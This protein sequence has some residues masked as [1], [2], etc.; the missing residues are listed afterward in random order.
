LQLGFDVGESLLR[1]L[2]LLLQVDDLQAVP[3]RDGKT[4]MAYGNGV[5]FAIKF[6]RFV[7]VN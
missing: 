4:H 3:V 1:L 6:A 2:C 5:V 7:F